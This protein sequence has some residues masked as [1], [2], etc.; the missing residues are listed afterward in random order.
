MFLDDNAFKNVIKNTPLISIDLVIQN[1]KNEYL[2]GKRNNRPA[3]GF[4]FVPGGRVQKDESLDNGFCR[5]TQ[6]EVGIMRGRS[7]STLLG[8]FEHFYDDNFFGSEFST[9]Y[10][11]LAYKLSF[12]SKDLVF[13]HD[14]HNE[15]Q[16]MSVDEILTNNLVH[17]NTKAYFMDAS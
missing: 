13:P 6:N 16:W 10:I 14:Q 17:F 7:E 11:V 1:E 4:W 3:R 2:V 15:Y 9:H 8:I 12:I 5:L